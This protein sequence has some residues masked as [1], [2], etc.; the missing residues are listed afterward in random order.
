MIGE[1]YDKVYDKV[2]DDKAVSNPLAYFPTT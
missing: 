1:V 2:Y